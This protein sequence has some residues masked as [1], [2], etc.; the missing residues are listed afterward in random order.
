M[1]AVMPDS[2]AVRAHVCGADGSKEGEASE[3]NA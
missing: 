2:T 3:N 1:A